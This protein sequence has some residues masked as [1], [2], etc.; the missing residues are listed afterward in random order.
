MRKIGIN[1]HSMTGLSDEEYIK[2]IKNL[3]FDCVFS[4]CYKDEASHV[5]LA[6]LLSKYG[7]EYETVHAPYKNINNM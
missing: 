6:E 5:A 3:G 7:I 4:S 1:M 2:K